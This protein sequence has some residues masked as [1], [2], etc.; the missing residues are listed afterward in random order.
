M[1]NHS[2]NQKLLDALL[3]LLIFSLGVIFDYL[4]FSYLIIGLYFIVRHFSKKNEDKHI[5]IFVLGLFLV[6]CGL[7]GVWQGW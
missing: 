3:P 2:Q 5:W 6:L 4:F 7:L 1:E